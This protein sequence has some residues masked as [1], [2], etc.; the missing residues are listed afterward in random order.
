MARIRSLATKCTCLKILLCKELDTYCT[1]KRRTASGLRP[2]G[3]CILVIVRA[4]PKDTIRN[5]RCDSV[6]SQGRRAMIVP[7][8][9]N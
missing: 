6:A 8:R 4:R 1:Q 7:R 5:L 9:K 2:T 3:G